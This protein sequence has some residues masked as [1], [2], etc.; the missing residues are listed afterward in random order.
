MLIPISVIGVE[1][2]VRCVFLLAL[3]KTS[4]GKDH[5]FVKILVLLKSKTEERS[6]DDGS[7]DFRRYF[8]VL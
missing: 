4:K 6:H 2:A 3:M 7:R 5:G 8:G 1:F